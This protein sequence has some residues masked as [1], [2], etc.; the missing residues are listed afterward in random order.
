MPLPQ[1]IHEYWGMWGCGLLP[2]ERMVENSTHITLLKVF[3]RIAFLVIFIIVFIVIFPT[4]TVIIIVQWT[5]LNLFNLIH[6]FS[7]TSKNGNARSLN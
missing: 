5:E 1:F 2:P 7:P 3:V 6:R 4:V